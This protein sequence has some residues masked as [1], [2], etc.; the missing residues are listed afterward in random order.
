[1]AKKTNK[2]FNVQLS[3]SIQFIVLFLVLIVVGTIFF[4][5][6]ISSLNPSNVESIPEDWKTYTADKKLSFK[7][8]SNY[9]IYYVDKEKQKR[10]DI[11][12]KV[13]NLG[14]GNY[15]LTVDLEVRSDPN[16]GYGNDQV[17]ENLN[18]GYKIVTKNGIDYQL[19]RYFKVKGGYIRA[20]YRTNNGQ[21]NDVYEKVIKS[22]KTNE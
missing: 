19:D 7:Y 11:Y 5:H 2:S 21:P 10:V 22:I 12:D 20:F 8:P 3:K 14:P 15:Y 6:T 13:E 16:L 4:S 9:T 17:R 1:M 18:D